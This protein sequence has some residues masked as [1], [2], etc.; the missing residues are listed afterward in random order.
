MDLAI[1]ADGGPEIGFGHLVRTGTIADEV[2]SQG[3]N[4]TYLTK[5]PD[6]IGTVCPTDID[7]VALPESGELNTACKWIKRHEPNVVLIDSYEADTGYQETLRKSA[8]ATAVLSDD[9]RHAICADI[10][11]NGNLYANSL[12]Y[13]FAGSSPKQLLGPKYVALREQIRALTDQDP[14]WRERPKRAIITMG[15]SDMTNQTPTVIQAFDRFDLEIDAIVGPG[16]SDTQ[17]EEIRNVAENVSVDVCVRRDPDDLPERMFQA[18]FAVS[19]ASSTTYELLALGTPIVSIP[20]V[21][22]Q[23]PIA[24]ALRER[25]AATVLDREAGKVSFRHAIKKYEADS[26]LRRDRR[27]YGRQL[28]DGKGV[29]RIYAEILSIVESDI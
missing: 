8:R 15:G 3:G 13:E 20:V 12:S 23:E 10:L 26:K 24:K 25:D 16:F 29:E 19:T 11:I 9:T 1:R 22:N 2:L 27:E 5:T 17:E 6:N 4:V 21:A 18:D 14:P 7:T 28:V